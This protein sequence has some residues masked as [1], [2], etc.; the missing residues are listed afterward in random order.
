MGV[1]PPILLKS[2]AVEIA[3]IMKTISGGNVLDVASGNGDFIVMLIDALKDYESFTGIDSNKKEIKKAKKNLAGKSVKI[4]LM[5]A[6]KLK[7]DDNKFDFV[8]LANSLHH[9]EN[10]NEVLCEI[11]R[12][13][14]PGGYLIIQEMF[15]D[16]NQTEAQK[17]DITSHTLGAEIDNILGIYHQKTYTKKTIIG[18]IEELNLREFQVYES[19]RYL[20]CLFCSSNQ[21]CEDPLNEDLINFAIKELE[22]SFIQVKESSEYDRL[23]ERKEI[24]KQN[25][26]KYGSAPASILFFIGRK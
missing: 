12:V 24:I 22:D 25:I 2:G 3:K 16:G 10:M 5:N 8:C 23:V 21:Q 14:K 1:I 19:S 9:L 7:F 15:C 17:T 20:K 26:M 18:I 4:H 13:L 6:E 11:K